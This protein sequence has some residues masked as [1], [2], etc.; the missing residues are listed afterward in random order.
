M[1]TIRLR[2]GDCVEVLKSMK[3]GEIGAIICDPPYGLEFMGKEWD[4]LDWQAG[5]GMGTVGLGDRAIPWPSHS[6]TNTVG[7]ANATCSTCG[8]RMRG[9]NKCECEDPDW[10]V[11][12]EPLKA[13]ANADRMRRQQAW[14]EQWLREAFRVLPPGGVIKAF[15]GTRTYH[16]L[17]AAM[18]AV[19]FVLDPEHSL[20]AWVYGCLPDDTEILTEHGW[21]P[22]LA[23]E[24]GER[25]ACW[26]PATGEIRLDA[27]QDTTKAPFEGEL[28]VFRNDNTDQLLTPNHRV[29]KKHRIR[30]MV[31]GVRETSEEPGWSVQ[32]ADEINRW[33]NLRLPLAGLHDGPG[34]GGKD[35]VRLLAW[36]WTEGGFD[37][38]GTGVRIYQSSVNMEHVEEIRALASKLVPGHKEYSRGRTY[39]DRE[40]TE[41]CWYFSGETALR[42]RDELPEKRPTWSLIWAMTQA[43]KHAF[44]EAALK[45]DGSC[46]RGRW[47]FYQ[48]HPDDLVWFQTLAHLMNRQGRINFRKRVVGLHMNPQTQLQSRH[49]KAAVSEHYEG[50][51]WCVRVRTGAFLARRADKVFITGNSGFPKSLDISKAIDKRHG[52]KRTQTIPYVAPDGKPRGSVVSNW[53]YREDGAKERRPD[54]RTLPVTDDAKRYEGYGSA[55]KPAWEPV[56]IGRK[57]TAED[58]DFFD[59]LDQVQ[60]DVAT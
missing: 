27:V 30:Q 33:N 5:G 35:W 58:L 47:A 40:Y 21:K 14:H 55:L 29:Y 54:D 1:P 42:V 17:A 9:A 18:E 53:S 20:E 25:V 57:P 13:T 51:V 4:K 7:T 16:R 28:I 34:A 11:K 43:E 8:G 48:K 36:V 12:G 44:V 38:S 39:K 59:A 2:L 52:A 56:L 45:G 23:V 50:M 32:R 22:G 37:Q 26:D 15:S 10:R 49:L 19:G 41:Y 24:A 46:S 6:Q 3:P 60:R 31:G